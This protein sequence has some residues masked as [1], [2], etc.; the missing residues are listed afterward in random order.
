MVEVEILAKTLPEMENKARVE[1]LRKKLV[2]VEVGTLGDT[3]AK[4]Q[5][6]ALD[7]ALPNWLGEV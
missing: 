4:V 3:R 7:I 2:V 5:A 6:I 1:P